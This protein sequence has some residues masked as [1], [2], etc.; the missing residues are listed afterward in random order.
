MR[1]EWWQHLISAAPLAALFAA[2]T[3]PRLGGLLRRS[4]AERL[5]TRLIERAR[6]MRRR[7]RRGEPAPPEISN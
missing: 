7:Q 5:D 2:L 3:L 1:G 4:D 6:E